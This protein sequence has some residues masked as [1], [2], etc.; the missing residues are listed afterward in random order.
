MYEKYNI[1]VVIKINLSVKN[2]YFL[3]MV[4]FNHVFLRNTKFKSYSVFTA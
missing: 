4:L 2:I 3:G 1:K